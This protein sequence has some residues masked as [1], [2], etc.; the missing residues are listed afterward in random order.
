[1]SRKEWV[2]A[3]VDRQAAGLLAEEC[4]MDPLA[5]LL[6]TG[7]G[8]DDPADAEAFLD[9][10]QP[11]A[12]PF[13]M[14]D[15]D[16]A[17]ER[18]LRG[19]EAGEKMAVFGD[20]D[21]DGITAGVILTTYL[22]DRGGD[23]V[24]RLPHRLQEGYGLH[25]NQIDLLHR[26][27]VTLIITVDNGISAAQEI[28][29]A[30]SLGMDTVVTDHHLPPEELP[31]AAAVVDPHRADEECDFRPLAGVG[32]AFKLCCALEGCPC[33]E[34][35]PLYGDLA[36]IGTVADVV[37]LRG[38]NRLLVAG[39]LAYLQAAERPGVQALVAVAGLEGKTLTSESIA[40]GLAPRLNAAG[41]MGDAMRSARLLMTEDPE[42]ARALAGE[43]EE[44]NRTRHGVEA[45]IVEDAM[46]MLSADETLARRRLLVLWKEGWHPGV[47][48]IAAARLCEHTGKPCI[49]LSVQEGE[50]HGSAR[51]VGDFALYEALAA[52]KEY[53][54]AFGG[55]AQAAGMSLKEEN[56]EA[57][58]SALE[59][60][61]ASL[62]EMPFPRLALDCKL[63][64]RGVTLATAQAVE[65]LAPFGQDNPAPLF[66]LFGM[67]L[68]DIRPV[69][70]GRHLRLSLSRDGFAVTAMRFSVTAEEFPYQVGDRIDLAVALNV[71]Q[72]GGQPSLSV[73]VRDIRP[74]GLEQSEVLKDLRLWEDCLRGEPLSR[75]EV[76]RLLPSRD[77]V[78]QVYRQLRRQ[79]GRLEEREI[80]CARIGADF[81]F[82]KVLCAVDVLLELGLIRRQEGRLF[83]CP[84]AGKQDLGNSRL[85][86]HLEEMERQGEGQ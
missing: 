29:Y 50:A 32:V 28:A 42:E 18:I 14:K 11:L 37:S 7:R 16:R 78:G 26:E 86:R 36:A 10:D 57:F 56:L 60:Y 5:A 6:L 21:C 74:A 55:H 39:G 8:L 51:S 45:G 69:G 67:T 38:E 48:G 9:L 44:E 41:R 34:L 33:E 64:P 75:E 19:L 85:L 2:V 13:E 23:V 4:E 84:E 47:L 49:L 35:M 15:M 12:D 77:Q 80:L 27:G 46:A 25:R 70:A 17:V 82:G 71:G 76:A 53:L 3:P 58:S 59:T 24:L 79:D 73:V 63:T 65:V 31:Q 52:C 30:T 81:G 1:M 54:T 22:Q 66:G 68:E 61:A 72:Y 43:L 83:L 20:Y 40:F 62:G